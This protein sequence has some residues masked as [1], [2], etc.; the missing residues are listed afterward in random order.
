[1]P[2]HVA[3][4][5]SPEQALGIAVDGK[6]DV[7]SLALILVEAVTGSVPFA[8]TRRWPRCRRASAS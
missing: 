5:A 8:A 2:T 1:M 6:T 7:Y 4:Y 3:R